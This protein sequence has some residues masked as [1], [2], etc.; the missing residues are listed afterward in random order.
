MKDLDFQT[1]MLRRLDVL[2]LLE[3]ERPRGEKPP[4]MTEKIERLMSFG[5]SMAEVADVIGKPTNYVTATISRRK[6]R[7]PGKREKI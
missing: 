1:Q 3:L 7:L 5:L 4:T 6:K 2:I